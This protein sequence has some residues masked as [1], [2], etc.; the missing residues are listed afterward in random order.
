M[1]VLVA[2]L[3]RACAD[4][5]FADKRLLA[6]TLR[7][8]R[9]WL[10]AAARAGF[11]ALGCRVETLRSLA[12]GLAAPELAARGLSLAPRRAALLL[13]AAAAAAPG[14]RLRYLGEAAARTGFPAALLASLT[15]LRLCAVPARRLR[16]GVLEEGATGGDLETLLAEYEALLGRERLVDYPGVLALAAGRLGR[17]PG[18]LGPGALVLVPADLERAGLEA[19]L[20][21][22]LAPATLLE[23]PVDPP[24]WAPAMRLATAVGEA[25][26]VREV[27]RGCLA[28]GVPLDEVE[29]LHTDARAYVPLVLDVLAALDDPG[30][31]PGGEPPVTF[32]E[33]VPCDRSRPG[34]AL[35]AWLR[36]ELGGHPQGILV[37]LVREGLLDTG[38]PEDRRTGFG[39][40]AA[41]LRGVGIG[42][43]RD[44]YLPKLEA[45]IA[46]LE[47]RL[48]EGEDAAAAGEG[49]EEPGTRRER[50]GGDLAALRTLREMVRR[51]LDLALPGASGLE[52]VRAAGVFL[53][54]CA[55]SAD[56]FDGYAAQSLG[57][58]IAEMAALLGSAGAERFD[59]AA[60]LAALPA[61]T[62]VL[63]SGPRP[64]R[65]H[66][67]RVGGG[68]HSGRPHLFVVGLDQGR[69]PGA[70][71][72]DPLLLDAERARLDPGMP[73]AAARLEDRVASFR[74]LLARQRGSVTLSWPCRDVVGD[75]ELYPSPVLL[76]A[77]RHISG[78]PEADQGDL[79]AAVAPASFAPGAPEEALDAGEWWLWRLAGPGPVAGA[80]AAALRDAPHLARGREALAARAGEAFTPWDGLVPEAGAA[81]DP[82][83]AEGR[84]LSAGGLE[85]AGACPL[86]FFFR[87]ALGIAPPEE[88]VVDPGRWLDP[89]ARGLL[90]HELFEEFLREL[91]AGGRLP[92]ADRDRARLGELL[93]EKVAAA[94]DAFPP[95][96]EAAFR[97][98]RAELGRVAGIFLAEEARHCREAGSAPQ[99]LEVSLGL[100]P[101][102][103]G[104]ALDAA[105]PIRV[106]LPDG[107][108][109]R[110]RGRVDRVDRVAGG[111]VVWD[112][113]TGSAWGYD[114][115]DPFV[116]GR[117][118]QPFLYV[119]MIERRLREAGVPEPRVLEAGYFFPGVKALGER[120][121]WSAERLAAGAEVLG[122][123]CALVAAGAF[124]PTTD[125][126]DCGFCDYLPVCGDV[127]AQAAASRRKVRAAVPLAPL[128][129]LRAR[130]LGAGEGGA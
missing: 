117:K 26:E 18:A 95:P 89:L 30:A 7:V 55:R 115:A 8:G 128:R 52:L 3:A 98:E 74:R 71:L 27:L 54:D 97:C 2:A 118:I 86:R 104:T 112:Y 79:L 121:S 93:E 75:R 62:R 129:R 125:A 68:G 21:A 80:E 126:G 47:R 102:R 32:A 25:N 5:P 103:H 37:A 124:L 69:F 65:L 101:G 59:A 50:I 109:I 67:D 88:L 11:P 45:R 116:E 123:L 48:R 1:N 28:S 46:S 22:A 44:R 53:R 96:S 58:E 42:I 111:H 40:L 39:R 34:R 23:L 113:K 114:R 130:S 36:W 84:V 57:R 20:L 72:Q 91:A 85:T 70:G 81:L 15:A 63:G 10:D 60:W 33:G 38:E 29:L 16:R 100:P 43:G 99:Y 51:L 6:P 106:E 14:R 56:R 4:R 83:A 9:Q 76:A 120:F 49:E 12:V 92:D 31:A 107:R 122:E 19:A 35:A 77:H 82:T 127:E 64:G 108:A 78:R 105:E 87:Y 17:E 13:A 66:V 110:A 90:L 119:R 41:L 61:E 94:L 24:G 73:T